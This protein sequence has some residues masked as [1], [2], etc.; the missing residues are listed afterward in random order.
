MDGNAAVSAEIID[1]VEV[2]HAIAISLLVMRRPPPRRLD[3]LEVRVDNTG[4]KVL[5]PLRAFA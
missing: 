2:A 3:V 5:T 1:A 4:L